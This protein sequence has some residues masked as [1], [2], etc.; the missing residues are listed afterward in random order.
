M[1]ISAEWKI[2]E[3]YSAQ[4]LHVPNEIEKAYRWRGNLPKLGWYKMGGWYRK[5][6]PGVARRDS[7]AG[8]RSASE[9]E[10]MWREDMKT[11][12]SPVQPSLDLELSLLAKAVS[13]ERD[14]QDCR[15]EAGAE[16]HVSDWNRN[17]QLP[18]SPEYET[19]SQQNGVTRERGRTEEGGDL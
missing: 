6:L 5:E 1:L 10:D 14:V 7:G 9:M 11:Q 13:S 18:K 2:H 16:A 8:L 12:A 4:W 19:R 15:V 3:R 17:N